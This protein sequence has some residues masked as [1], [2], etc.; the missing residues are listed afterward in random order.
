[1]SYEIGSKVGDY[2][3]MEVLGSGGMGQVYKVRNLISDRMEAMKVLLPNLDSDHELADRFARVPVIDHLG[4]ELRWNR[5]DVSA[6]ESRALDIHHRADASHYDSSWGFPLVQP[7]TDVPDNHGGVVALI[8]DTARENAYL[9][10]SGL[11]G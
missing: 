10:R 9:G 3:V 2:Q 7:V 8:G 4:Q 5:D 1:M 11:G 6:G